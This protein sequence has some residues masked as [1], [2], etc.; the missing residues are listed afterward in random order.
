MKRI[1]IINAL[2]WAA[3]I[4]SIS[5]LFKDSPNW[6]Y[7]LGILVVAFTLQNGL[8]SQYLTRACQSKPLL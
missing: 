1:L 4:L 2:I 5:F 6:E 7:A 3:V 8:T